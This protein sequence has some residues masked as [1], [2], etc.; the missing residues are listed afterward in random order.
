MKP[1]TRRAVLGAGTAVALGAPFIRRAQAAEFVFKAAHGLAQDH[2]T[3]IRLNEAAAAVARESDGRMEIRVFPGGQLGGEVDL[4]NQ[5]RSGAVEMYLIGGLV[6]SS[7]VPMAALDGTGFAFSDY[8]Q[9]WAAMDGKLGA[10]IR[11]AMMQSNLYVMEKIWD[12][13]FRQITNSAHPVNTLDDIAGMK[14]RVPGAAAY[15]DLF[16]A[17]GAAPA[18][19]QFPEVYSAL[20]THIVDGQENPL[21]L[22]VTSKLYEV[23]KYCSMTNHMWNGFWCLANGR[24]WRRLPPDLQA[25][26]EKN[27]NAAGLAQRQDLA[28]LEV[29]YHDT[30]VKAGIAIN[31]PDTESFRARLRTSGYYADAKRKFGEQAWA[32]L[33]AAGGGTLG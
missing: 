14:I 11:A 3:N 29:T 18:N 12:L 23:Q 8:G 25:I 20:Q 6:I 10:F 1:V 2:P 19:I 30:L 24:A 16:K 4:L 9:V 7:V 28:K 26:A 5:V 17:L 32:L 31:K 33:E 13:G 15:S 21:G 27:L 22:I